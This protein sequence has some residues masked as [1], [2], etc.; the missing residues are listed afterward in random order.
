M[1]QSIKTLYNLLYQAII[2]GVVSKLPHCCLAENIS[3]KS[4]FD[5]DPQVGT[6][7]RCSFSPCR[8]KEL[9]ITPSPARLPSLTPA[10]SG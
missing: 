2:I 5:T 4:L 10:L 7:R 9:P 1:K 3:K 8:N 6:E